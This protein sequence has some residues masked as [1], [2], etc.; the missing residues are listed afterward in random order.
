MKQE[1]G[2][3]RN[4]SEQNQNGDWNQETLNNWKHHRIYIL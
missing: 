3:I 2:K 1:I 4:E